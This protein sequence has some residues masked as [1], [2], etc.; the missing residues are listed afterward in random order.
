MFNPATGTAIQA[1]IQGGVTC[2]PAIGK[3]QMRWFPWL[4][5]LNLHKLD[6]TCVM[7]LNRPV[8]SEDSEVLLTWLTMKLL[9]ELTW[10]Q[11]ILK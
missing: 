8:G 9:N 11:I 3:D 10:R 1:Q 7:V 6:F 5:P 4:V 2:F